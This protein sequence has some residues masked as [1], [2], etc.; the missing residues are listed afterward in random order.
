MNHKTLEIL[1]M[2]HDEALDRLN[3]RLPLITSPSLEAERSVVD[4]ARVTVVEPSGFAW[5][6]RDRKRPG[7][8]VELGEVFV[9]YIHDGR[10]LLQLLDEPYPD[11]FP[12]EKVIAHVD[13]IVETL[14]DLML[15]ELPEWYV[16]EDVR[17]KMETIRQAAEQDIHTVAG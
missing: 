14:A 6:C 8:K 7:G 2:W 12:A 4:E 17:V 16:G 9:L 11:G 10:K 15:E 1:E 5:G 13:S 3:A